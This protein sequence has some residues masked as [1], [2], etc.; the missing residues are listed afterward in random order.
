MSRALPTLLGRPAL[1]LLE[2]RFAP[3]A[4]VGILMAEDAPVLEADGQ[5]VEVMVAEGTAIEVVCSE[6][7]VVMMHEES[8]E[9]TVWVA[10]ENVT[11]EMLGEWQF[12][13]GEEMPIEWMMRDGSSEGSF[14]PVEMFTLAAASGEMMDDSTV[15]FESPDVVA[16]NDGLPP[17]ALEMLAFSSG[18]AVQ[19][20]DTTITTV[21]GDQDPALALALPVVSNAPT[22]NDS[23][24]P[25]AE[26][27]TRP[28]ADTEHSDYRKADGL[29]F[30][31]PA[32]GGNKRL[33][34]AEVVLEERRLLP[35]E[36]GGEEEAA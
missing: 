19:E 25:T 24:T 17:E 22:S 12:P 5:D 13:A 36:G 26:A 29:P 15:L 1:E 32:S 18:V 20:S 9:E 27:T 2:S 35:E 30:K 3:S 28:V 7:A 33:Q 23:E 6:D 14:D 34:P 16:D 4:D 31:M 8:G 11:E 10:E 21:D